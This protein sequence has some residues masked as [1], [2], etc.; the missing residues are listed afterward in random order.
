MA[1]SDKKGLGDAVQVFLDGKQ[2]LKDKAGG[3]EL[4][5]SHGNYVARVTIEKRID[6][7]DMC[8]VAFNMSEGE[9]N[10]MFVD[11]IKEGTKLEIKLGETS[12]GT[13]QQK[14]FDGYITYVELHFELEG[15]DA[16]LIRA[17]DYSHKL[18]RGTLT[19]SYLEQGYKDIFS[20]L[21]GKAGPKFDGSF[22][23]KAGDAG[24][25]AGS[26]PYIPFYNTNPHAFLRSLG[27]DVDLNLDGTG[28][29]DATSEELSYLKLDISK[30]PVAKLDPANKDPEGEGAGEFKRMRFV[31]N[32]SQQ[33]GKVVVRGWDFKKKE[34]IIAEATA[35]DLDKVGGDKSLTQSDIAG[36]TLFGD[37]SKYVTLTVTDRPVQTQEEA[38][39]MA[40]SIY[41]KLALKF[42]TGVAKI[43]GNP[44]INVSEVV[45]FV[46]IGD[47]FSGKY[48]VTSVKHEL[49][50]K[51]ED[52]FTTSFEFGGNCIS[53]EAAT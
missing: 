46:N 11:T 34:P 50:A 42:V 5:I 15:A 45:E 14:V 38:D 40:K 8:E 19:K 9:N 51:G 26:F 21:I 47:R 7:P 23:L 49:S 16:L 17:F 24:D 31:M 20:E 10:L 28:K 27:R 35:D 43:K 52:N 25:D 3:E 33:V 18:T 30:E 1:E 37:K 48:V 13:E 41:N 39:A 36:V 53:K 22:A 29:E 6:C 12:G 2:K 4:D 32:T 44:K